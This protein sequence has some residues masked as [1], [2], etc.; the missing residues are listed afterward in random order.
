MGKASRELGLARAAINYKTEIA[1]DESN[2]KII[3]T[4][5]KHED[6]SYELQQKII[7]YTNDNSYSLCEYLDLVNLSNFI[8]W[9][10]TR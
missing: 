8:E 6:T 4:G 1:E 7:N 3:H 2:N 5:F 9:A 10:Q